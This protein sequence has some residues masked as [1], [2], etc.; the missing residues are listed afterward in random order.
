[1]SLSWEDWAST[2]F[3]AQQQRVLQAIPQAQLWVVSVKS[4]F[5]TEWFDVVLVGLRWSAL[6]ARIER[7]DKL[8]RLNPIHRKKAVFNGLFALSKDEWRL[9]EVIWLG[10]RLSVD[11]EWHSWSTK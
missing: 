11:A 4:K 7:Q 2:G 10:E 5:W 6:W 8:I 1:M 9:G 3:P